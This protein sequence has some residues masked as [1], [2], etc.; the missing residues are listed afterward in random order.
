VSAELPQ[1]TH[2]GAERGPAL[3]G[4]AREAAGV[5]AEEVSDA[6][7]GDQQPAA[8]AHGGV[9][10]FVD[11]GEPDADAAGAVEAFGGGADRQAAE[12]VGVGVGELDRSGEALGVG[13]A[14]VPGRLEDAEAGAGFEERG[15]KGL[16]CRA[17]V[18]AIGGH[19][20]VLEALPTLEEVGSAVAVEDDD[21]GVVR[22]EAG[23]DLAARVADLGGVAGSGCEDEVEVLEEIKEAVDA[24]EEVGV[25]VHEE[26]ALVG[27]SGVHVADLE[28]ESVVPGET[29]AAELVSVD[30]CDAL[31]DVVEDA[32]ELVLQL[33]REP[34]DD[35]GGAGGGAHALERAARLQGLV[36]EAAVAVH[37][38]EKPLLRDRRAGNRRRTKRHRCPRSLEAVRM[39]VG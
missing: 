26:G 11:A 32:T 7:R 2:A 34:I 36:H 35:D 3:N 38:V 25:G 1:L 5:A 17:G 29:P 9:D 15:G 16:L 37:E 10:G 24:V 8:G 13:E 28:G 39:R 12:L 31:A 20:G 6:L 23:H 14:G 21:A 4:D 22:R 33:G 19:R 30:G 27:G 18:L